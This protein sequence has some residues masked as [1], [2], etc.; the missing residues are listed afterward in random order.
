MKSLLYK[1]IGPT[2]LEWNALRDVGRRL[3][4]NARLKVY[5]A[6]REIPLRQL[7]WI[8]IAKGDEN[9]HA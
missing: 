4:P 3:G 9:E 8:I 5:D 6:F 2:S 1:F 7:H